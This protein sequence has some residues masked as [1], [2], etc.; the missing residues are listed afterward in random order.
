MENNLEDS[1]VEEKHVDFSPDQKTYIE[2]NYVSKEEYNRIT[3][4]YKKLVGGFNQLLKEYNDL[5]IKNLLQI[6]E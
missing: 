2:Q 6:K 1:V 4:E 5:H 3:E